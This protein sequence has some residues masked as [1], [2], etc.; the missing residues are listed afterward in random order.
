[1]KKKGYSSRDEDLYAATVAAVKN[2]SPE[3]LMFFREDIFNAMCNRFLTPSAPRGAAL[4]N[5]VWNNRSLDG[6]FARSVSFTQVFPYG[7]KNFTHR[8][9]VIGNNQ[10][11]RYTV[12]M[13]GQPLFEKEYSNK[14]GILYMLDAQA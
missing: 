12:W 13:S 9:Q 11:Y 8:M 4:T 1:M 2:M 3:E 7:E 14:D 6:N 10:G 5:V